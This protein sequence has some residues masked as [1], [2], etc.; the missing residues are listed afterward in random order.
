MDPSSPCP[1]TWRTSPVAGNWIT[2]EDG[3]GPIAPIPHNKDLWDCLPDGADE[4]TLSDGCV[5]IATINDLVGS[6]DAAE[7]TGG[8]F[9]RLGTRFYVSVQ[10]NE[11][12]FGVI[13]EVS[14]WQ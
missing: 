7:W 13:Y 8:I 3:D 5:R 12:G 9:N 6:E 2:H 1:I 11:T 4:D 14:G 10:H